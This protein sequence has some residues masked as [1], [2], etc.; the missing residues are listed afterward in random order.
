[1]PSTFKAFLPIVL[2]IVLIGIGSIAALTGEDTGFINFLRFL[3]APSVAFYS[4]CLQHFYYFLN[5]MKKR[6]QVGLVMH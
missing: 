2:P 5:L 4:V 6:C 3:G 1:M